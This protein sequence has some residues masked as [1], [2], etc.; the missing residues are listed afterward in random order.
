MWKPGENYHSAL[1]HAEKDGYPSLEF[2]TWYQQGMRCY[3]ANLPKPLRKQAFR[4]VATRWVE[5]GAEIAIWHLRAFVYGSLGLDGQG[6]RNRLVSDGFEWPAQPDPSW[7][8]IACCYPD[9]EMDLDFAHPVSRR[10]WS[11]DNGFLALPEENTRFFDRSWYEQMGFEVMMMMPTATVA[12]KVGTSH[13]RV[14]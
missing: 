8:L 14:V 3:Q 4:A 1:R 7:I 6:Q 5:T 13:L 10:F 9:G 2:E 11:E 12:E